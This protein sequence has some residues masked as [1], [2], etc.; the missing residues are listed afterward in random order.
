MTAAVEAVKEED[1]P[2]MEP[3]QKPES[4]NFLSM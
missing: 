4:G 3:A 2:L 1:M